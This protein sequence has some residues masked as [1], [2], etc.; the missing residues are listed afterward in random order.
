MIVKLYNIAS[1]FYML[2][3]FKIKYFNKK[4]DER[5]DNIDNKLMALKKSLP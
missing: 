2:L 3:V 4:Q 1:K 5:G